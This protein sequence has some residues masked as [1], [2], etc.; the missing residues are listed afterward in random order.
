MNR[1]LYLSGKVMLDD[2]TAPTEPV[3]LERVCGGTPKAVAYT[4]RKGQFSFQLNHTAGVMQDA[5]EEESGASSGQRPA[6]T[7]GIGGP[8]PKSNIPDAQLANCDLRAVMAGFRSDHISLGGRRLLDDPNVG[9]IVLHRLT[10]VQGTVVSMTTLEAPKDAKKAYEKGRRAFQDVKLPEAEKFLQK[11]VE[12]DPKF[13]AAWYDLGKVQQQN[14]QLEQAHESY[15]KALAADAKFMAPY[16]Q[17]A[18]LAVNAG[19]WRELA[20]T[21]QRLLELDPID[22]PAAY[23]YNA[24]AN[25]KLNKIDAAEKSARAGEKLDADHRYPKREQLLAMILARKRDYTAAAEHM[26]LY[27]QLAPGADDAARMRVQLAEYE[28]LSGANQQAHAEAS[29]KDKPGDGSP[30]PQ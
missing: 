12:I 10:A 17:L 2:G 19:R 6:S 24:V 16:E 21:T 15:M 26:R 27:L 1:D 20:D 22:H 18:E 23:F 25:L 30:E 7:S 11:A 4:D 13:A 29:G 3:T 9:T 28:R 5:S 14:Q 8:Q